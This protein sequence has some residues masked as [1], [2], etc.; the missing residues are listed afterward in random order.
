MI[1]TVILKATAKDDLGRLEAYYEASD[2]PHVIRRPF[3]LIRSAALQ[4]NFV[5][6]EDGAGAVH[7]MMGVFDHPAEQNGGIAEAE[8]GCG[9]VTLNNFGLMR[10]MGKVLAVKTNTYRSEAVITATV[11]INDGRMCNRLVQLGF[12]TWTEIPPAALA[13]KRRLAGKNSFRTYRAPQRALND[14]K[15]HLRALRGGVA[16]LP[17]SDEQTL[18]VEL[19]HSVFQTLRDG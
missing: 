16:T 9:I 6:I 14:M 13:R 3:D 11:F 2:E 1:D 18:R 17:R 19:R 15:G 10:L 4:G 7:G 12:E 5:H 8:I